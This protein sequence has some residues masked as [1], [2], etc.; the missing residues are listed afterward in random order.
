MS[1]ASAPGRLSVR[2]ELQR[3]DETPDGSGGYVSAW[4]VVGDIWAQVIPIVAAPVERAGNRFA[5]A[6]HRIVVRAENAVS[7]GMRFRKG[8]RLFDID[9]VFDPD[10]TGRWLACMCR[11]RK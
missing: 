4:T 6:T 2:L 9:A 1:A 5:E 7:A 8:A 3:E 11:E 10:E